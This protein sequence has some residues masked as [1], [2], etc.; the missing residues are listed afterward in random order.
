MRVRVRNREALRALRA[1]LE[2]LYRIQRNLEL[3]RVAPVTLEYAKYAD[4]DRQELAGIITDARNPSVKETIAEIDAVFGDLRK[5]I[6]MSSVRDEAENIV[7]EALASGAV[8]QPAPAAP[9]TSAAAS[10]A[11]PPAE[12]NEPAATEPVEAANELEPPAEEQAGTGNAAAA[13]N[14]EPAADT[15]TQAEVEEP[16]PA[17]APDAE[18]VQAESE[19]PAEPTAEVE[20]PAEPTAEV[21]QAKVESAETASPGDSAVTVAEDALDALAAAES[22]LNEAV[23]DVLG[24]SAKT[25]APAA[26]AETEEITALDETPITEESEPMDSMP[27]PQAVAA[28]PGSPNEE[29]PAM[30]ETLTEPES[31]PEPTTIAPEPA[32]ET[33]PSAEPDPAPAAQELS[34][35]PVS[36]APATA[37]APASQTSDALAAI[38]IGIQQLAQMLNDELTSQFNSGKTA[39]DELTSLRGRAQNA[40]HEIESTMQNLARVKEEVGVARAEADA[41]RREARIWR[42]DAKRAKER[43]E[44]AAAAAEL[45]ADQATKDA[46]HSRET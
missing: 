5:E 2:L 32:A 9:P 11:S 45:A 36:A 37:P 28:E 15:E 17:F 12:V 41:A 8:P 31:Q 7:Q 26:P 35:T 23:T 14:E 22:A 18:T 24:E 38:Q 16:Q 6:A 4:K 3:P 33:E 30:D 43:A 13:E 40:C 42:D 20:A 39:L 44:A 34:A 25:V 29:T 46:T 1:E 19:V 21:E 10:A 27:E